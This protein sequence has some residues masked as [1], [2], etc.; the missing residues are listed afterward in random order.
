MPA[1]STMVLNSI[2]P[3]TGLGAG[4][5]D[6]AII[7]ESTLAGLT[8]HA[9]GGQ[10]NGVAIT[11]SMTQFTTVAT[12]ADSATLPLAVV[13]MSLVI[14][15]AAATNSMN[16]FPNAGDLSGAG[17]YINAGA[18]NAAYALAAGHQALFQCVVAGHWYAISGT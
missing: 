2:L 9:G 8:A 15:N 13:G 4:E 5:L 1:I 18:Q 10:A 17:G 7:L 14:I 6:N 12:A 11:A 16:I 3:G